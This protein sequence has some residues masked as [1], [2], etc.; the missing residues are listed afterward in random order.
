MKKIYLFLFIPLFWALKLNGQEAKIYKLRLD[1][2][3]F[4]YPQN[5]TLPHNYPS[6]N[7]SLEWSTDFYELTFWGI[8]ELGDKLFRKNK[9]S[10]TG[11]RKLANNTFKYALS[12][13]LSKYGSEL[14][15]PLGVWAHEEFHRSTLGV[16]DIISQNG[17][18]LFSRWDGTVYGISDETL[19]NLKETNINQLLYSYVSGVQ[20]EILL[21]QTVTLNDFYHK[22]S[23][24]KNA[25]LL[26][27]AH[28]VYNYFR[29]SA[30]A[31]SDTVKIIA[32]PHESPNPSERDYAGA[33]LTSWVYDMFNP[34]LP[35][36]SRDNFPDGE[37]VN[38]RVGFSDLS[39]DAQDYL[40]R[41]KKLSL[42]NFVNPAIFFINRINIGN[43]VSFNVFT[44]YMPTHFG[45]D[46]ALY[47]PVKIR[48]Y[49][50]LLN[51]HQY[52]A[53]DIR[54]YGAGLGVFNYKISKLL[55]YD[56]VLNFWNQPEN[57]RTGEKITG[58][59]LGIKPK[60]RL[61][62]GMTA[63]L[64]LTGKTAG[65]EAGTPFLD[66]NLSG[67]AGLSWNLIKSDKN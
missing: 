12:L 62:Q 47:L 27:N 10:Y 53:G 6:M 29:F 17:N 59:S 8:D 15:I 39:A 22:R 49:D 2:P 19:D 1:I 28:Y 66:E 30:S 38:R 26:Y 45:N 41:Q 4:D 52:N 21:N 20:Y 13:G 64:C 67:Q 61:S 54:G 5:A 63:W 23:F 51:L 58:G 16:A 44:R 9:V 31:M 60:I 3:F 35:F 50:L 11:W 40:I 57:F 37:G 48:E 18:W 43:G 65:W 25:L 36:T 32:P 7:Q 46:I 33:D 24:P 56:L 55:A 14:P 42:L 34:D